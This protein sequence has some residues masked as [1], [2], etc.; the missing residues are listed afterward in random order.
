MVLS[1]GG[2]PY[3]KIVQ[4]LIDHNADVTIADNDGVTPLQQAR[5]GG[6]AE[7]AR[8]LVQAS[9]AEPKRNIHCRHPHLTTTQK[10]C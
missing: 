6:F 10:G 5:R 1:D 7:I 8:M 9:H 2:S 4:L 3:Q